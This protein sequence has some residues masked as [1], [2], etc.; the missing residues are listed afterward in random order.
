VPEV[1]WEGGGCAG[2]ERV[3]FVVERV[4]KKNRLLLMIVYGFVWGFSLKNT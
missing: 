2:A 1:A 4:G 3:G